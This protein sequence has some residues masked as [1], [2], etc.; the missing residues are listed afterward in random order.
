MQISHSVDVAGTPI[1]IAAALLSEELAA[2]R[3]RALGIESYSHAV[4]GTSAKTQV[5]V[6]SSA[7]PAQ[8]GRFL[9]S[10][11][12][13]TINAVADAV[14]DTVRYSTDVKGAPVSLAWVVQMTPRGEVT[15]CDVTADLKVSIPLFGAKIEAM[16]AEQVE[17][18]LA[19]DFAIVSEV[20][21]RA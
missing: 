11:I 20:I 7:L 5:S 10:D 8:V 13:V 4:S 14:A 15:T 3:A 16:A 21:A 12:A 17:K 1:Q 6:P 2:A 9:T 18:V 19:S